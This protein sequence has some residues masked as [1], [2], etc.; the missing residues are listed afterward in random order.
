MVIVSMTVSISF[1]ES[2]GVISK[3]LLRCPHELSPVVRRWENVSGCSTEV[4]VSLGGGQRAG[5]GARGHRPTPVLQSGRAGS[6]ALSIL[7]A[8]PR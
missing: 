2:K 7:M 3:H 5:E 4:P 1:Q 8:V 6:K